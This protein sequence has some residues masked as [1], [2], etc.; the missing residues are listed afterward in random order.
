[1]K[2]KSKKQE[3]E[4][5]DKYSQDWWNEDGEFKVLHKIRPIRMKYILDQI[6]TKKIENLSVLD[7]GCGGGLICEPLSRLGA[8][9]TGVDFVEKNI[10]IALEHSRSNNLDIKYICKDIEKFESK[11]KYDL[12]ILF[13]VLEH[14]EDWKNF[15]I[16]IKNNLKNNGIIIIST[17]NRNILS[18]YTAIFLAEKI[19][20]WI[21]SGTHDFNKFIKPEEIQN[22]AIK[23]NFIFLSNKGLVYNPFERSWKISNN[24]HVN[25][26]CTLKKV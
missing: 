19:L 11:K 3:Y 4:L 22:L 24:T 26:F 21:P 20:R 6:K 25:Y 23:E 16:K 1:M 17:I 8:N 18:K 12:I 10:K 14:L 5:F 13:E 9:V 15:V 7:I 2:L